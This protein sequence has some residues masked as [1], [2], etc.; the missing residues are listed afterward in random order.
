M[1]ESKD[2]LAERLRSSTETCK[3][4]TE[5]R[6]RDRRRIEE[7]EAEVARM[8]DMLAESKHRRTL[9]KDDRDALHA[10]SDS[11]MQEAI[12]LHRDLMRAVHHVC[13][14]RCP[15]RRRGR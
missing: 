4:L 13:Q 7:L 11:L 14:R 6:A 8:R 5:Q 2:K 12:G 15:L 1:S 9:L 10:K 3:R